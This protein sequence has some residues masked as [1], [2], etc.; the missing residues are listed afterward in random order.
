MFACFKV[1]HKFIKARVE[2]SA[3]LSAFSWRVFVETS[4]SCHAFD[5]SKFRI[6]FN[7]SSLSIPVNR[8]G[9]SD[10]SL[11]TSPIVSMLGWSLYF[12]INFI[13]G[14]DTFSKLELLS[15]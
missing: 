5:V 10:F 2:K 7:I 8:K 12:K 6:F 9:L 11:H 13:I 15:A 1:F 14:S 4:V 3:K